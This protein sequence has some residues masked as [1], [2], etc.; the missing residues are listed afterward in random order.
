MNPPKDL[1]PTTRQSEPPLTTSID[2]TPAGVQPKPHGHR[3]QNWKCILFIIFAIVSAL[4]GWQFK[5]EAK[6]PADS[7]TGPSVTISLYTTDPK[8]KADLAVNIVPSF[9]DS[10]SGK[11]M[12]AL[13][14]VHLSITPSQPGSNVSWIVLIGPNLPL[15]LNS[16]LTSTLTAIPVKA[17][18]LKESYTASYVFA[19]GDLNDLKRMKE[20]ES[21]VVNATFPG[22]EPVVGVD[23]PAG[24]V[25]E[26]NG[27]LSASL[28]RVGPQVDNITLAVPLIVETSLSTKRPVSATLYPKEVNQASGPASLDPAHYMANVPGALPTKFYDPQVINTAE[29]IMGAGQYLRNSQAAPMVPPDGQVRGNDLLWKSNGS[30]QPTVKTTSIDE[31]ERR[32]SLDF[33]SGIA[34]ATAAAALIAALQELPSE[35]TWARRRVLKGGR[36]SSQDDVESANPSSQPPRDDTVAD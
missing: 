3:L 27:N 26:T 20:Q 12:Q 14:D 33:Y 35:L 13:A 36:R 24:V 29:Q 17:G 32:S 7:V 16:P 34:L 23:I 25:T 4:L 5:R 22:I 8:A 15:D 28:P 31:A 11:H 6:P 2:E 19:Y 10:T 18:N 1:E 30:L 9:I 21:S